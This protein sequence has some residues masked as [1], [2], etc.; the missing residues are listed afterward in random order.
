MKI[1]PHHIRHNQ[2][3]HGGRPGRPGQIASAES[4]QM[5]A[6]RIDLVNIR[7]ATQKTRGQRL[8]IGEGNAGSQGRGQRAGSARENANQQ[9]G[10]GSATSAR[11]G[12]ADHL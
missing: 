6:Y 1:V 10:T 3:K 8:H 4:G 7:S 9:I 5:L 11:S 12:G 2:G